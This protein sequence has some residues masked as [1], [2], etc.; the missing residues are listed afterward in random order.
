VGGAD[1]ARQ[2]IRAGLVDELQLF[3]V[4]VLVGGGKHALP[5]GVRFDL[6]L[7]DTHQFASGAV[8]LRYHLKSG[9]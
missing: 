5:N 9:S 8:F 3:M 7:L 6:E 2:A 1:L 4:P